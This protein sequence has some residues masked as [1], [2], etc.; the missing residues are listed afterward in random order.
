MKRFLNQWCLPTLA[1]TQGLCHLLHEPLVVV[2]GGIEAELMLLLVGNPK[3]SRGRKSAAKLFVE[4]SVEKFRPNL[5]VSSFGF[6]F[7]FW[8]LVKIIIR[9]IFAV[10]SAVR[11]GVNKYSG[12]WDVFKLLKK[13]H[14]KL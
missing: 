9:I 10:L 1:V 4:L 3:T 7:Q 13:N 8:D 14:Q 11:H 2:E 12:D 5:E 6:Q